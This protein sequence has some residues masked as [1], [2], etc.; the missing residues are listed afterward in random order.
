MEEGGIRVKNTSNMYSRN[1][2]FGNFAVN[3]ISANLVHFNL[4]EQFLR[5]DRMCTNLNII[6]N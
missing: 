4:F 3:K 6:R 5:L 2:F 1:Y